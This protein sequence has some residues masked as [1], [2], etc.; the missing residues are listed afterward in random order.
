M[1]KDYEKSFNL[2]DKVCTFT[3]MDKS[4][5]M[6]GY[7]YF[8][9]YGVEKDYYEAEVTFQYLCKNGY[10]RACKA[11]KDFYKEIDIKTNK[12]YLASKQKFLKKQKAK[13]YSIDPKTNLMWQDDLDS[14]N[15][16]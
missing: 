14:K 3:G 16:K 15:L 2:F 8:L 6:K 1:S 12:L 10:E 5:M 11:L 4:C 13:S 9:G 7:F